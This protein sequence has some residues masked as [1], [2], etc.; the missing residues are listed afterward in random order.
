MKILA[1]EPA[2][3]AA[4][5]AKSLGLGCMVCTSR[6]QHLAG[7]RH[8]DFDFTAVDNGAFGCFKSGKPFNSELFLMNVDRVNKLNLSP[9]FIVCPDIVAG[10][11]KSLDFSMS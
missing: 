11:L 10:G 4:K 2:G 1:G 5:I 8:L 3:K 7:K 6:K 9:L